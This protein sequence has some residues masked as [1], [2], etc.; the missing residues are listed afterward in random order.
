MPCGGCEME[1][2]NQWG[3]PVAEQPA[4]LGAIWLRAL[5][6]RVVL[7]ALAALGLGMV[8]LLDTPP[9]AAATA[10]DA[11]ADDREADAAWQTVYGGMS[12]QDLAA[13]WVLEPVDGETQ[14]E[15]R[16]EY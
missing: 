2:R 14:Q 11:A 1:Y 5:C 6:L 16:D 7:A 9:P 4:S 10:A 8:P 12:E 15:V 3:Y 13:G